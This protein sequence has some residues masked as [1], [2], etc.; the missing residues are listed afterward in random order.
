[1]TA[2]NRL[3]LLALSGHHSLDG[4]GTFS[5]KGKGWKKNKVIFKE[6]KQEENLKKPCP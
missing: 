5:F 4:G 1:M 6:S 2:L 3:E